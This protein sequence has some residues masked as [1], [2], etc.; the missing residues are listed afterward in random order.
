MRST[1]WCV[2]L[3][4]IGLNSLTAYGIAAHDD[5][6]QDDL[7]K[8]MQDIKLPDLSK[9]QSVNPFEKQLLSA[10]DAPLNNLQFVGVLRS[11]KEIWGLIRQPSGFVFSVK[12][13]EILNNTLGRIV[14]INDQTIVIQQTQ[15]V[16][17]VVE[18]IILRR[19]L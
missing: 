9:I 10:E 15:R 4:L 8:L 17:N 13:G 1:V 19:H 18:N 2:G 16:G 11:G 3:C 5:L 6:K 14:T 12:E 7:K